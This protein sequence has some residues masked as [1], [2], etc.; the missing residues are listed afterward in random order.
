M[1]LLLLEIGWMRMMDVVIGMVIDGRWRF[2]I[3]VPP[4]G[5]GCD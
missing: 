4:M 3:S 5:C 1:M 2:M